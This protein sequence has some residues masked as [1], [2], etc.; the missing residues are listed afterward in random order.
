MTKNQATFGLI[1]ILSNTIIYKDITVPFNTTKLFNRTITPTMGFKSFLLTLTLILFASTDA[2]TSNPTSPNTTPSSRRSSTAHQ[3]RKEWIQ[4]SVDY[5]SKVMREER[6]KNM[7]YQQQRS[8]FN[9]DDGDNTEYL[10]LANKHYFALRKIK[11]GQHKHA[12]IIYRR[13]I[14]ELMKDEEEEE[15]D[16]AKLAITTL[17]LAL[18]LQRMNDYKK[19]RS[20]FLNFFR[21]AVLH[22][23]P[24]MQCACSAK[25]LGAYALF[26]MKQGNTNKSYDIAMR[27]TQ[28]DT[29]LL[30]ILQWKQFRN[31]A[32][33]SSSSSPSIKTPTPRREVGP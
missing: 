22:S 18:H 13:I 24:N 26:E 2:F 3:R 6:R 4:K 17:L 25:V 9:D 11:N 5:Y 12:E 19:T 32:L 14:D 8:T 1:K 20:V 33:S 29:D 15:C 31:V 21:V 10:E 30:P 23:D 27:A 28:F 16:H 7:G